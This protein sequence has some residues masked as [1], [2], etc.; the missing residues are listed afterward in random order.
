MKVSKK[1]ISKLNKCYAIGSLTYQGKPHFLVAAEKQDPCYLFTEE[2]ELVSK[3]WDGPGGVM[4]IAETPAKKGQ[5]LATCRFYSPND[6]KEASIIVADPK[7]DGTWSVRTLCQAPFVHRFGILERGGVHYLI[8]C[9][10]KS[11]HEYRD[12]WR[13]PGAV[14]SAVLPEDLSGFDEE[15]PLSLTPV[16]TGMLRNHGFAKIAY[17]GHEAAVV[18]CEEGT[19]LF[20]PPAS[21]GEDWSVRTLCR[22]PSS[23][24]IWEDLDGDGKR[25]L[26]CISPFH[27]NSLTIYHEDEYGNYV[28][29]WKYERPEKETEMLHATW[30]CQ[31][32]GVPIWIAGWRKGTRGTIAIRWDPETQNYHTDMLDEHAGCANAMHFVDTQGKDVIVA[33]NREIDEVAMY[34]VE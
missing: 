34:T 20:D 5:F 26:G 27:G 15:H 14:Y 22:V 10:L 12:D 7:E 32:R 1:V 4:T 2:G 19:F 13:F 8:V 17:E 25:E 29:Q 28:P 23:D 11:G 30:V 9:C 3:I 16:K 18:A 24:S 33:A 6:S 31:I 21:S